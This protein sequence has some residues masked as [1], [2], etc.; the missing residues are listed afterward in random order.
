MKIVK[1]SDY[2]IG[3][4]EENE[5]YIDIYSFEEVCHNDWAYVTYGSWKYIDEGK[6]WRLSKLSR[7]NKTTKEMFKV[8]CE[9]DSNSYNNY[10]DA[11][12]TFTHNGVRY[13]RI[14]VL[15]RKNNI[16]YVGQDII[17]SREEHTMSNEFI[18]YMEKYELK[19]R[20]YYDLLFSLMKKAE[21]N[22]KMRRELSIKTF[23]EPN[24]KKFVDMNP[25]QTIEFDLE[26]KKYI[27]SAT[28]RDYSWNE[29]EPF[30]SYEQY[31]KDNKTEC[32]YLPYLTNNLLISFNEMNSK[33]KL[34]GYPGQ[35]VYFYEIDSKDGIRK[36]KKKEIYNIK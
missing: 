30:R 4:V 13:H 34:F 12:I 3:I 5:N 32:Q 8:T 23:P 11:D 7:I 9:P 27:L 22:P 19:K 14:L 16:D 36:V 1:V 15:N 6:G 28:Y 2:E 35:K 18:S 26:N 17:T 29:D 31:I 20:K 25:F 24:Y 21:H 10:L 33:L